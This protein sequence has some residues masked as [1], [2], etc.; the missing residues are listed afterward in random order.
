MRQVVFEHPL[1]DSHLTRSLQMLHLAAAASPRMESEVQALRA[2]AL[3]AFAAHQQK[4][5]L[6]PLVL[7]SDNSD[8]DLLTRERPFDKDDLSLSVSGDALGLHVE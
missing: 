6:L 1:F 2:N 3:R 4:I 8:L 7:L 5:G